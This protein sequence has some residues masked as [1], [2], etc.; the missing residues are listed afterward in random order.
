[1]LAAVALFSPSAFVETFG[2][3]QTVIAIVFAIAMSNG[4]IEALVAALIATP[5]VQAINSK[6]ESGIDLEKV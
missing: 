6:K 2:N 5:I 1:M 3:S 4:L